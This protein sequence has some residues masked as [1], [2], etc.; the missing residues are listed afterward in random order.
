MVVSVTGAPWQMLLL[1]AV[2]AITG[3]TQGSYPASNE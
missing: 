2:N 3:G 1:L